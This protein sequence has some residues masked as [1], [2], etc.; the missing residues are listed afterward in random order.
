M[1]F[2]MNSYDRHII[3][4]DNKSC[5]RLDLHRNFYYTFLRDLAVSKASEAAS[6]GNL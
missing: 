4:T 5:P 6:I 3:I 2:F 1:I